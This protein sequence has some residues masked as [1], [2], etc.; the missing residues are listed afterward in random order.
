MPKESRKD[1]V[2]QALPGTIHDIVGTT[3]LAESTIRRWLRRMQESEP[4]QAHVARFRRTGGMR[5]PYWVAGPGK[6]AKEP[7]ALGNA[8]WSRKSRKKRRAENEDF[9]AARDRARRAAKEAATTPNTWFSAL[10]QTTGQP[11]AAERSNQ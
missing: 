9:R 6:D 1:T 4:K 11:R 2:L 10:L 3:G 7:A 8:A 5:T